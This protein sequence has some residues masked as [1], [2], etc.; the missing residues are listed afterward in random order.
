MRVKTYVFE[1]VKVGMEAIKAQYGSDT[2]IVDIKN[3]GNNTSQKNCEISIAV[4]EE[5][6]SSKY[7]LVEVRKKT[8]EIWNHALMLMNE[9]IVGIENDIIKERTREYPLP[10]R[11]LLD[12]LV[13]NGFE[14]KLAISLISEVY[15]EIGDAAQDSIRAN[16]SMRRAMARQISIKSLV[17]D[18]GPILILGPT[19]AGKTQTTK[20]LARILT[21]KDKAI[22]IIAYDPFTKGSYDDL[23]SFSESHGLPFSFTTN[24]EDISFIVERDRRKKIIDITGHLNVQKQVLER[25][26][27]IY[28]IIVLPAGARDDKM[29][30]Y[31]SEFGNAIDSTLGFTKLDEEENFGHIG[32]NLIKLGLPLSFLTTGIGIDEIVIPD[33]ESLFKILLEGNTWKREERK[34]LP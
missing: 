31:C 27:D 12:K 18:S 34:L 16:A 17:E 32:H 26:R 21:S 25:L 28:K 8:E 13:K 10:L 6:Q 19:G 5:P 3:N 14:R 15:G 30:S 29:R 33:H 22:S 20:K 24:G 7:D 1:D 9:R 2:I 11:I 4:D 23:M